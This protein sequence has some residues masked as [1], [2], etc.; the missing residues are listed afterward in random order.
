MSYT[1]P[2]FADDVIAALHSEGYQVHTDDDAPGTP[3]PIHARH[4]FTWT[5]P[6]MADCEVGED[7]DSP[8]AAWMEA[9]RHWLANSEIPLDLVDDAKPATLPASVEALRELLACMEDDEAKG[10]ADWCARA[11]RAMDAARAIVSAAD[12][13]ILP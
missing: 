9:L 4:W 7:C 5:A 13:T 10:T 3:G 12:A 11:E 8:L 6:G 1:T 2:D